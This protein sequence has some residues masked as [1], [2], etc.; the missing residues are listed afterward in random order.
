MPIQMPMF[1]FQFEVRPKKTHPKR[2]EYGGA[3]VVCWIQRDTQRQA[4]AVARG[5]LAHE[6]WRITTVEEEEQITKK[7]Q[8]PEGL[9]YFEQA[10]IDGEVFVFHAWPVGA[11]DE[12]NAA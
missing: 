9:R 2:H 5:W 1:F 10:E 8:R 11:P 3:T 6:D 12:T 7:D 4:Q